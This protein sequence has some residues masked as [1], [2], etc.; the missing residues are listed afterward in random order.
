MH[1]L[2]VGISHRTAPVELR[3]RL[4]MTDEVAI[5]MLHELHGR[6]PAAE[7]AALSTCNRTELFSHLLCFGI[8]EFN[9]SFR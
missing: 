1:I 4:A 2:C 6:F 9:R 7:L 8:I 3:E 5:S